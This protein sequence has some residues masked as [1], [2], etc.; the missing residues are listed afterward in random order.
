MTLIV[1][2]RVVRAEC[3]KLVFQSLCVSHL[4]PWR[5]CCWWSARFCGCCECSSDVGGNQCREQRRS[6]FQ[7]GWRDRS[8]NLDFPGRSRGRDDGLARRAWAR[9][10]VSN[11]QVCIVGLVEHQALFLF[12]KG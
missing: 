4:A 8:G 7:H 12:G 1:T 5:A 6:E 2:E 10:V 11:V 9:Q 3:E